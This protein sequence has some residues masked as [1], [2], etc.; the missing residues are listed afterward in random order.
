MS[1]LTLL[2]LIR[3]SDGVQSNE[4]W[5]LNI[6][7]FLDDELTPIPL[8]GL[9]FSSTIGSLATLSTAGGQ[10]AV[11]GPS[12]NVLI[13]TAPASQTT[14][15]ANGVYPISLTVS[16]GVNTRALFALSTLT[17][18]AAQIPRVSLLVAPDTVPRAV[19]APLSSALSAALQALQPAAL[20]TALS[21]LPN[22][23]LQALAQAFFAALPIQSGSSAPVSIGQAFINSSGY[24]VI[25]Q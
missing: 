24:V 1:T 9:S 12:S 21:D 17:V 10:I 18:G 23:Q 7:F 2:P 3:V 4:D 15:W 11:A 25:A 6:A 5:Q 19:A 8:T 20:A 14:S 16:D 22:A 13:I